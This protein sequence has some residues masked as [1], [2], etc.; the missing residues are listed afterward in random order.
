MGRNI[1]NDALGVLHLPRQD[2]VAQYDTGAH[3]SVVPDLIRPDLA[4]HL[5]DG[6]GGNFKVVRRGGKLARGAFHGVF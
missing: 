3:Q 2:E 5:V 4:H 1:V 6:R